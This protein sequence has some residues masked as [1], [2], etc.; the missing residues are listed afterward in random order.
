MKQEDVGGAKAEAARARVELD[1]AGKQGDF[2][3]RLAALEAA[4]AAKGQELHWRQRGLEE[5]DS[6]ARTLNLAQVR[7]CRK[8]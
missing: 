7:A 3:P 4:I 2:A 6:A 5:V 8:T 1:R